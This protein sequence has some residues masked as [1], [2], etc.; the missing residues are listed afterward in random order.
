MTTSENAQNVRLAEP[1]MRSASRLQSAWARTRHFRPVLAVTVV[2]YAVMA[3]TQPGFASMTNTANLLN[4]VSALWVV[5]MG[6]TFV[7]LT[8]GVDLSV[9]ATSAL[10]GIMFAKL[11]AAGVPGWPAVAV[12]IVACFA[13]GAIFNGLLI[14]RFQMSFFVITLASMTAITGIVNLWSNTQSFSVNS[15]V[16][17]QVGTNSYI[18]I[19]APIWIMGIVFLVFLY[20]QHQTMAGRDVYA[21]G[22]SITAARLSGIRTSRTIML[23]YGLSAAC[24]AI[25]AIIVVGR[26]GVAAPNVDNNLALQAVAGV[27]L[28]GTSLMGGAG[29]VGGT[30]IGV[31]FIGVLQNGLSIAGVQSFWQQVITGAILVAAVAGDRLQLAQILKARSL[32]MFRARS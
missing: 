13:I 14:G 31:I 2:L 20:L 25:A 28:G 27:L 18:G 24:G 7:L 3:A 6:M 12:T 19:P 23:V 32:P 15:Q 16:P 30:A 5:A 29:G 4:A 22:G 1:P 26:I 11:V 8:A 17:S 21:V 10:A 9:A